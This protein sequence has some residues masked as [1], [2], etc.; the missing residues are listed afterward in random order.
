M[1]AR[2]WSFTCNSGEL[3]DAMMANSLSCKTKKN[4]TGFGYF[5]SAEMIDRIQLQTGTPIA[6]WSPPTFGY[7]LVAITTYYW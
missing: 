5:C 7:F 6:L 4:L 3:P 2:V 1:L